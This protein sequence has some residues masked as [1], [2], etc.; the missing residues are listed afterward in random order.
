MAAQ[1]YTITPCGGNTLGQRY[2]SVKEG[3]GKYGTFRVTITASLRGYCEWCE[4]DNGR[5]SQSCAHV[6]A[7]RRWLNTPA[8]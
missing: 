3:A 5:P 2:F 4:T 8:C 7:V 1:K 6:R